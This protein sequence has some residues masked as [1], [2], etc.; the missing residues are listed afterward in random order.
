MLRAVV[1]KMAKPLHS[2]MACS[3]NARRAR[4]SAVR[5]R[6]GLNLVGAL[7]LVAMASALLHVWWLAE[8]GAMAAVFFLAVTALE[9]W[10]V[11][12]LERKQ[13]RPE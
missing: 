13:R 1:R 6:S 9:Y 3:E 11:R 8:L 7:S 2:T 5:V 12:R 4:Q 10:N